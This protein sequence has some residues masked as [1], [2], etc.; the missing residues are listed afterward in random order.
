MITV[1]IK[2]VISPT[3]F[4]EVLSVGGVKNAAIRYAGQGLVLVLRIGGQERV[5]GQYRGGPRYFS[6]LD[7][8][9]SVLIQ[10]GIQEFEADVSGWLPRTLVRKG[11]LLPGGTG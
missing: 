7:G 2:S 9:A 5:L 10:N 1:D 8:A 6:T 11:G 3:A 4:K